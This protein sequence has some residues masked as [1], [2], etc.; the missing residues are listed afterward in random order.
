MMHR[1]FS[2]RSSMRVQRRGGLEASS[3]I[4]L[5]HPRPAAV[6]AAVVLPCKRPGFRSR[7]PDS[8]PPASRR[9]GRQRP[10]RANSTP[11]V[12]CRTSRCVRPACRGLCRSTRACQR[13]AKLRPQATAL[14]PPR[15]GSGSTST[16]AS[17]APCAA[18]RP[19]RA[20]P[21][22]CLCPNA[23]R[24]RP[25]RLR[26]AAAPVWWTPRRRPWCFES[27]NIIGCAQCSDHPLQETACPENRVCLILGT[28]GALLVQE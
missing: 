18:P 6:A 2:M 1:T 24:R 26:Q 27:L 21:Q 10:R 19:P 23:P 16:A 3:S 15:P 12:A 25:R 17:R 28:I 7:P 11:R 5:A 14:S 20:S 22:G 4:S 8:S 13:R 9:M